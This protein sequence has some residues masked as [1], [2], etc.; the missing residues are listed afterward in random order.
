MFLN[1]L[2]LVG[3]GAAVLPLVLH[4]LSRSRYKT[5]DWS[6]MMFLRPADPR[7]RRSA[8]LTHWLLLAVRM[9]LVA[10]LAVALARPVVRG[11]WGGAASGGRLAVVI[12]L[13][14][15]GS[16]AYEENGVPRI[17]LARGAARQIL[18]SLQPG[19]AAGLVLMG[20]DAG[21]DAIASPGSVAVAAGAG[22][23]DLPPTT[24][25]QLVADRVAR[26]EVGRGTA[27]A[28]AAVQH[29]MNL[30][31]AAGAAARDVYV[32]CDRQSLTWRNVTGPFAAGFRE[33]L[34][35]SPPTRVRIVPV[36]STDA[37]NVLIESVRLTS[38]PAIR[39]REA[40]LE[41]RVRN[42]GPVQRG[43]LP[44]TVTVDG[45]VRHEATLELAPDARTSVRVPLKFP[46]TG[47][48]L[49][50]ATVKSS[51][52]TSD[53][54]LDA[55]VQV[56]EPVKVLVLSGD[57]RPAAGPFRSEA[58]FL[59]VALLPFGEQAA[60]AGDGTGDVAAVRVVPVEQWSEVNLA[61]YQVVVLA[62]V[63]LPPTEAEAR[64][65]VQ[66]IEKY[67]YDGGGL[68]VTLGNLT[69]P[70]DY[71]RALYRGG[72][73]VLPAELRPPTPAGGSAATSVIGAEI[74]AAGET[75]DPAGRSASA[76]PH[77]IFQFLRGRPGLLASVTV[78]RYFPARPGSSEARVLASYAS[79]HPF[80]IEGAMP[81]GRGRVLLLTTTIDADW[82]TLPLSNFYLPFVQ[83]M[84]RYLCLSSVPDHDLRPDQPI[85]LTFDTA[86]SGG[87][88][89][90]ATLTRPDGQT[91][92]LPL[93]KL[94][95]RQEV[96]YDDTRRPGRYK[97]TV[98]EGGGNQR[99]EH[100]VVGP[101]LEES[102]LAGV[103]AGR[104]RELEAEL[105]A[106]RVEPGRVSIAAELSGE[107]D[108]AELWGPALGAVFILALLEMML[109]RA[110][111]RAQM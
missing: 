76:E 64:R 65:R 1:P 88:E 70:D 94:G 22:P 75:A 26:A 61:D 74:A 45:E 29:A 99:V 10:T 30:L 55:A 91:V 80:L 14:C 83:S 71:N 90:S 16:M 40:E 37:Q 18:E 38:G 19:D 20:T 66:A 17:D 36:G 33:R 79:G 57:E 86:A 92:A 77:P 2:M 44:L 15:S 34:A 25:L 48:S 111:A 32:V 102:N 109:G 42:R 98:T 50:T 56:V 49:V 13:D 6:G 24:D 43:G 82:G 41:V 108:G 7:Q 105:S 110:A 73:G 63:E 104:W 39:G 12:V 106:Q 97:V 51:G 101:P 21:V 46:K 85:R 47:S 9:A 28:A 96:R 59:R 107:R 11:A 93:I 60:A 78:G 81:G 69:R 8:R 23:A 53:D 100:F 4:L 87:G 35:Q 89:R 54:S 58:D 68:L 3:V 67:V 31:H 27:D 72:E 62:N 52:L 5:V 95:P 84:V 103:E